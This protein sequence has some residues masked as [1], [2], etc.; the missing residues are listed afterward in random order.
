MCYNILMDL[1][2]KWKVKKYYVPMLV[3][4]VAQPG[5]I[6]GGVQEIFLF[7]IYCFSG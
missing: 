3:R 7:I 5:F 1:D 2:L 4:T 6:Q